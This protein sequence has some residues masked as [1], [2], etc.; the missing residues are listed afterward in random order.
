MDE[1]I[2][3]FSFI[4][5]IVFM[6]FGYFTGMSYEAFL[7]RGVIIFLASAFTLILAHIVIIKHLINA[8]IE[9]L[10]EDFV[11]TYNVIKAKREQRIQ[12]I[13]DNEAEEAAEVL[14][15]EAADKSKKNDKAIPAKKTVKK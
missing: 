3:K 4:L 1:I 2:I 7:I 13:E 6:L 9:V 10:Q 11:N 12:E 5:A 14:K 8:K 15:R